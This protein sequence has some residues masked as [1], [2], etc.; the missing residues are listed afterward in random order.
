M[1]AWKTM[2]NPEYARKFSKM[3]PAKDAFYMPKY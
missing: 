2:G 3:L 1:K